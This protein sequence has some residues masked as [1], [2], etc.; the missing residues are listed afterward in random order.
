M[1]DIITIDNNDDSGDDCDIN[2]NDNNNN[3]SILVI[4]S[5]KVRLLKNAITPKF[6]LKSL[7]AEMLTEQWPKSLCQIIATN[8]DTY[9][10]YA[11]SNFRDPTSSGTSCA[12][13]DP[14][15]RPNTNGL[16]K[17]PSGYALTSNDPKNGNTNFACVQDRF[18]K[19]SCHSLL[20]KIKILYSINLKNK[21]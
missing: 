9:N 14:S 8:T 2:N 7:M 16:C 13:L 17:C 15:L 11:A 10:T 5:L 6:L 4:P 21:H 20:Y 12:C 19:I 18:I 1:H 3:Y